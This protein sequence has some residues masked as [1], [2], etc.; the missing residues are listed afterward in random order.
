MAPLALLTLGLITGGVG[1]SIRQSRRREVSEPAPAIQLKRLTYDSKAFGPALSPSGEFVAYRFH[2][3]AQDSI[4]LKNVANGSTVQIMPPINE[5]YDDLVFSPDKAQRYLYMIDGM[6]GE[7][8]V[9][10]RSSMS[11]L[12]AFGRPGRQAGEFTA[13]HNIAVDRQG[14]LYTSE[15]QTGQRIQKF[16]RVDQQL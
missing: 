10:E 7:I 9:I 15:V 6:N 3:G 1:W 16:R 4:K 8:R 2:D 5:G 12:A 14:N 13:L 11:V